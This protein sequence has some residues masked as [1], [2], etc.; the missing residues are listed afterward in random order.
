[1][2]ITVLGKPKGKGR[3]RFYRGHAVTPKSTR[4]YERLIVSEVKENALEGQISVQIDAYYPFDSKSNKAKR[5]KMANNE[6]R[7]TKKP[8][9]DNVIKIVLD[10]LNGVAYADDAQVVEVIA[11]KWFSEEPRIEIEVK[12]KNELLQKE[13]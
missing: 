4:E 1:M 2:K 11:N 10:A 3:P 6:I 12:E 8:D 7:P 9:I 5:L 13:W